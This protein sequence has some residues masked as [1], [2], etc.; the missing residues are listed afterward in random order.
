MKKTQQNLVLALALFAAGGGAALYT[1]FGDIRGRGGRRAAEEKARRPLVV[2]HAEVTG[3]TLLARGATVAFTRDAELGWRITRPV[4]T[5]ADPQAI[6]AAIDRVAA[7]E[8]EEVGLGEATPEALAR[9]GLAPARLWIELVTP[10]GALRLDVGAKNA[11]DGRYYVT[12][13]GRSGILLADPAFHW[14]LDRSLDGLRE[15]RPFPLDQARVTSLAVSGPE[16]R[17][18]A[19]ERDGGGWRVLPAGAG[20]G[21]PADAAEVSF[22]LVALLKRLKVEHFLADDF[23]AQDP[24]ARERFGFAPPVLSVELGLEGGKRWAAWLGSWRAT[25]A[26]ELPVLH[27]VGS[28]SVFEVPGWLR[29]DLDRPVDVLRDRALSRFE[30]GDARTIELELPRGAAKLERDAAGTWVASGAWGRRPAHEGRATAIVRSLSRLRATQVEKVGATEAELAS[31]GLSPPVR[32]VVVLGE[33]GARLAALRFGGPAG[34][35][36]VFVLS[37][38]SGRVGRYNKRL[39][40][41]IPESPED[42]AGD[43]PDAGR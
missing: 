32:R 23:D 35:E 34:S 8:V 16:G 2:E 31:W 18:W 33:G 22:L 24:A 9:Y 37:E 14:A 21:E 36:E 38:Q 19:V 30:Q 28:T 39:L 27:V 12:A 26:S 1:Y 17:R 43:S 15:P 7:I 4:V 5:P 20:A 10:R 11:L 3:G 13:T 40:A 25:S 29:T 41:L 6:E 42:L